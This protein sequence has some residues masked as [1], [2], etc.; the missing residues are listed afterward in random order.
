VRELVRQ[1]EDAGIDERCTLAV[2]QDEKRSLVAPS[3]VERVLA[4]HCGT[5]N[6]VGDEIMRAFRVQ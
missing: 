6:G 5:S 1:D 2:R 4:S 3:D